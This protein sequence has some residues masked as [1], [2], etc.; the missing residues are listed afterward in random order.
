MAMRRT[1]FVHV[2]KTGGTTLDS[3]LGEQVPAEQSIKRLQVASELSEWARLG[4][5]RL[6]YVSGH[7]PIGAIDLAQF[8][9]RV[10][11]IREPCQMI[12]SRLSFSQGL[13]AA[14]DDMQ[15]LIKAGS[16]RAVYATYF[17]P[18][19]DRL[20]LLTDMTYGITG[21]LSEYTSPCTPNEAFQVLTGFHRVIDFDRLD[22]EVKRLIIEERLFPPS[23]IVKAR[24][25]S[26]E[27][28]LTLARS[29]LSPFDVDFY[30]QARELF[31]PLPDT[32]DSEYLAYRQAYAVANGPEVGTRESTELSL[33]GPVG[34]GWLAPNHSDQG[35]CFRWCH[36]PDPVIDIPISRPGNYEVRVYAHPHNVTALRAGLFAVDSWV[37]DMDAQDYGHITVLT[38]QVWLDRPG[39]LEVR[40]SS[41]PKEARATSDGNMDGLYFV[42]GKVLLRR[43]I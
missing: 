42:L 12:A 20:R 19:C 36:R 39:W 9:H 17:G 13:D 40:C 4:D 25:Y 33:K 11:I 14:A 23:T 32:I 6:T 43:T 1:L 21:D 10:T 5:P 8:H 30:R 15:S 18:Q 34:A 26:Y 2:P 22:A 27:P 28:D 7:L 29:L 31:R 41:Q 24:Q 16:K 3:L 37:G 38:G 35:L